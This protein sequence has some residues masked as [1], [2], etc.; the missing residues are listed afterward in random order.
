MH[1]IAQANVST[2]AT[3]TV[4]D[5]GTATAVTC[6]MTATTTCSDDTHSVTIPAGHYIEVQVANNGA[7]GSNDGPFTA[8]FSY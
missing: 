5:N 4:L 1:L 6:T 7:A 2:T 3:I 8:S